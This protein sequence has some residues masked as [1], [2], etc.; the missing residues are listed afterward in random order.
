MQNGLVAKYLFCAR[1]WLFQVKKVKI[2]FT[3]NCMSQAIPVS[4]L[5][6][7]PKRMTLGMVTGNQCC[8]R[9]AE[10]EGNFWIL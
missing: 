1:A 7:L 9:G 2:S 8:M 6:T 4:I 5:L 10:W 3:Q